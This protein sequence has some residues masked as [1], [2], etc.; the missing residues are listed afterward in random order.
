MIKLALD[1]IDCSWHRNSTTV[2]EVQYNV[3]QYSAVQS[4]VNNHVV[5]RWQQ[6]VGVVVGWQ[7][8]SA[9]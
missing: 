8:E 2:P 1:Q 4:K 6:M 3:I 7:V 5:V 9:A